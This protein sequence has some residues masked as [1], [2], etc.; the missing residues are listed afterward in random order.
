MLTHLLVLRA[1]LAPRIC[2]TL[3]RDS[4]MREAA[5]LKKFC[6]IWSSFLT[7]SAGGDD[8]WEAFSAAGEL[9][10]S[11]REVLEPARRRPVV[12]GASL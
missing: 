2:F 9:A 5:L 8:V 4:I 10:G 12:A 7:D 6:T 3:I 11:L 1:P